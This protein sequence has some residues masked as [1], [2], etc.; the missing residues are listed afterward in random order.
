MDCG[1]LIC[2]S[3]ESSS[4]HVSFGEEKNMYIY[5]ELKNIL[6]SSHPAD[7]IAITPDLYAAALKQRPF[8]SNKS[9]QLDTWCTRA[10]PFLQPEYNT[11]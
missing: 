3:S 9:R 10:R 1:G 6:A 8:S 2:C 5:N 7:A 4:K 11:Y